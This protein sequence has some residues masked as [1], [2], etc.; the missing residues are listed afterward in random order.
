MLV[1]KMTK[2]N[3]RT[4]TKLL[5]P[6]DTSLNSKTM[7]SILAKSREDEF[8]ETLSDISQVPPEK[9]KEL[10]QLKNSDMHPRFGLL[11][12]TLEYNKQYVFVIDAPEEEA[13][14]CLLDI[15]PK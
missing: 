10:I 2:Q 5:E 1:V 8:F 9:L 14:N 7:A 15:I 11:V 6:E 3:Y 12:T 13:G 4:L